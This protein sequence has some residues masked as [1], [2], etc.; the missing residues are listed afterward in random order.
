MDDRHAPRFRS[1]TDPGGHAP[2]VDWLAADRR[3]VAALTDLAA[4]HA[5]EV[6]A[7]LDEAPVAHLRP[8]V[9]PDEL[10]VGGIGARAALARLRERWLPT[11]SASSG[12]RYLGYVTGGATPAALVGDWVVATHDNNVAATDDSSAA[13]LSAT[14]VRMFRDLLRLPADLDGALVTG[15]TTS[16]IAALAA[17]RQWVGH[18]RGVDVGRDGLAALGEVVV[19]SASPHAAV[20]KACRVLG[21]GASSL[22]R[23]PT[24]PGREAVDPVALDAALARVSAG[25]RGPAIVVANLGTVTTCD[26]DDVVDVADACA[27]HGA[28][29][30]VDAAFAGLAAA[31]PRYR[32]LLAGWERADSITVDAHK[33]ANVPYDAAVVLTRRVDLL[34]EVFAAGADYLPAPA[35]TTTPIHL[36]PQNSQRLRAL[37]LWMSLV[38]YGRAG[39]E[40]IV[41]RCCAHATDFG[42]AVYAEPWLELVAPVRFNGVCL[43]VREQPVGGASTLDATA[44]Q[45][46]LDRVTAS[47][48]AFLTPGTLAGRAVVRASFTSWRTTSA[49]VERVLAVLVDAAAGV[50]AD[51]SARH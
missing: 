32:S 41:E 35:G 7:G 26:V 1:T 3:D 14:T 21:L 25:G 9:A 39:H 28:W 34:A 13:Q 15:A 38:A 19:L 12:P 18:E 44:T 24:L 33:W 10:S 23:V 45:A 30:H 36:G 49:D 11:F 27:R 48:E 42:A 2:T 31:S 20:T 6:L 50:A 37:P 17:A 16:T 22:H 5:R 43:A 46:V 4:E 29:L 51:R 47:G 40:A 8:H